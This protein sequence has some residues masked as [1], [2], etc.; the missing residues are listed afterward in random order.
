[1][2]TEQAYTSFTDKLNNILDK[3]AP[4]KKI[5]ISNKNQ[6]IDPWMSKELIIMAKSG[7]KLY[8]KSIGKL[9]TD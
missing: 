8:H 1:M 6:I 5:T 9:Q 7:Y 4:T 2:N 3:V